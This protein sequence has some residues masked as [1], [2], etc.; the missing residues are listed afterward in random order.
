MRDGKSLFDSGDHVCDGKSLF[1]SGGLFLAVGAGA[2][3][4]E[5]EW[6]GARLGGCVGRGQA[7]PRL[8]GGGGVHEVVLSRGLE[9]GRGRSW[10]YRGHLYRGGLS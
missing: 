1:D 8:A 3:V 10:R 5:G 4:C 7:A 2:R 9:V 6:E